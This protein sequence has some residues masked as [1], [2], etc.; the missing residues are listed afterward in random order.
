VLHAARGYSGDMPGFVLPVILIIA[1]V[2]VVASLL[3]GIGTASTGLAAIKALASSLPQLSEARQSPVQELTGP[4]DLVGQNLAVGV[5]TNPLITQVTTIM[6]AVRVCRQPGAS[7]VPTRVITP[8]LAAAWT[9]RVAPLPGGLFSMT[10]LHARP[11]PRTPVGA[12]MLVWFKGHLNGTALTEYWSFV[13]SAPLGGLPAACPSCGAPTSASSSTG[14]CAY[15]HA[16]L[17]AGL[18][19]GAAPPVWLVDDISLSP[20]ATAAA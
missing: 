2:S 12:Q 16:N 18:G 14:V 20:P 19:V 13:T 10:E 7:Q 5:L 1:G 4:I 11:L 9:Q 15:C 3:K 17:V 8:R 6:A